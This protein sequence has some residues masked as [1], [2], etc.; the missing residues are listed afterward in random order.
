[1][2]IHRSNRSEALVAEL[3]EI[4][5]RPAGPPTVP[6]CIVVQGRGME[7]WL[8]MQLARHLS[9]WANPDFPFPRSIVD[10]AFSAV[11]G[12]NEADRAP[13]EPDRLLWSIARLLPQLAAA[14]E[15]EAIR[16]F[17]SGDDDLRKLL[18]LSQR[19][20]NVLDRYTVYRPDLVLQWEAGQGDDWQASLWRALVAAHSG[21]REDGRGHTAALETAF[22]QQVRAGS[23]PI[24]G[25]PPRVSLFGI[26]ALP[27]SYVRLLWSLAQRIEI[28]LFVLSPSREYWVDIRS[29][30]EILRRQVERSLDADGGEELL[31]ASEGNPLLAS[32]GRLQRDFQ[33]VLEVWTDYV[34]SD[35]DLY[36]EPTDATGRAMLTVLQSDILALRHRHGGNLEVQPLQL[37]ADD[38]SIAIHSC[39]GPTRELEV[40]HDQLLSFFEA[41]AT[42]EPRDVVVMTPGIEA[43]APLIDAVFGGTADHRPRIPYRIADRSARAT[44]EV[45]DAFFRVLEVLRG[46]LTAPDVL[47]L[48][49]LEVVRSAFEIGVDELTTIRSWVAESGVRWGQ[50]VEDRVA[51]GQPEYNEN[52][53]RFGLDRLLLGYAMPS[54]ERELFAGVLPYD[55]IEGSQAPVLGLLAE[56]CAALF[57]FREPLSR[58]H[59]VGQWQEL[60]QRL[61]QRMISSSEDNAHQHQTVRD[62]LAVLSQN[63]A[64]GAFDAELPLDPIKS[65]LSAELERG[66]ST[67]GFL[68]GGVTFCQLMPMRSIPFRVICLLGMSDGA[69]PR[70][71]QSPG[72]DRIT[73]QPRIGDRTPR[74]DDRYLML[75]ALLSAR[76]R[77]VITYVG[78]SIQSNVDLPPSVLVGELLDTIEESFRIDLD[79]GGQDVREQIVLTHP[80]QP[81]SPRY[82]GDDE[83]ARLFSYSSAYRDGACSLAGPRAEPRPFLSAP[84]AS[85]VEEERVV[86]LDELARFFLHPTRAFVQRRLGLYLGEDD[87]GVNDR[88][89]ITLDGLERWK[90]GTRLLERALRGDD[91]DEA[92]ATVRGT[93]AL[94][95]GAVGRQVYSGLLLSVDALRREQ[96]PW[97]AGGRL[98]SIDVDRVLDGTR[99]TGSVGDLWPAARLMV[100]FASLGRP[101]ELDVWVR[102]VVL[103]WLRQDGHPERS[104]AIG[105]SAARSGAE[106]AL[107][108]PVE[109][110][111]VVLGDLLRLYRLGQR[112]PLPFFPGASRT[113]QQDAGGLDHG[114]ISAS[115]IDRARREF[116]NSWDDS[117]GE[118]HDTYVQQVFGGDDPLDPSYLPCE[119]VPE[120]YV[121]FPTA[122]STVFGPLLSHRSDV[123]R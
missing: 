103:C 116:T 18:Q 121:N 43:Y 27:P 21:G 19:I 98:E 46:R 111:E 87:E 7:R 40:L 48:L 25:F 109:Q 15:F 51:V 10:R 16:N 49:T 38:H 76:D 113:Y 65:L 118:S 28:H 22:H 82:F 66:G 64:S 96:I 36:R 6:E 106:A 71:P 88:E 2:F 89:P 41:D 95:L 79:R 35:R 63:A 75:E 112:V 114:E 17:L 56:F 115:A 31:H 4:V 97:T 59:T 122:A 39:H 80:L 57:A 54:G 101:W 77:L 58:R 102:H 30:R 78:Q 13:Y 108:E 105:W 32:L 11:L 72:F 23:G 73:A 34:E 1:M 26:S 42:L 86:T 29:R 5:A 100:R 52:T 50:D 91:L 12:E 61:L 119:E 85:T 94:P 92:L 8:A 110:P 9:V 62:A 117:F 120:D 70:A 123:S 107:F 47:D 55:D 20:A 3:A 90:L 99:I 81:F 84:L 45:V 53:W 83:D 104:V 24:D 93:G 14:P 68:A 44:Q 60:L 69:F 74:D 67:S 37:A 33:Q